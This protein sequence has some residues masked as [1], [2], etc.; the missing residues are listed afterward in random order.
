MFGKKTLRF[1]EIGLPLFPIAPLALASLALA[2]L[3]LALALATIA[4]LALAIVDPRRSLP[5]SKMFQ[6]LSPF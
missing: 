3:A 6:Y 5:I 4:P 1:C 2:S